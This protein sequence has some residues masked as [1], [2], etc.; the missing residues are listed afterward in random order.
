M[1]NY[2]QRTNGRINITGPNISNLFVYDKNPVHTPVSY[3]VLFYL[4]WK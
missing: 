1:N 3:K 4:K 2:Y